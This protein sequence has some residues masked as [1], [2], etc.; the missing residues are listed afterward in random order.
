MI[1]QDS[2]SAKIGNAYVS[3]YFDDTTV[4]G[5]R[6]TLLIY[7]CSGKEFFYIRDTEALIKEYFKQHKDVL[8]IKVSIKPESETYVPLCEISNIIRQIKERKQEFCISEDFVTLH[9]HHLGDNFVVYE[10]NEI[11]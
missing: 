6:H 8:I 10:N 11:L 2:L 1:H 5:E 9:S 7:G 3:V 4:L